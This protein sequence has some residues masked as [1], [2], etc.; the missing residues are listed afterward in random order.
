MVKSAFLILGIEST[1]CIVW[2]VYLGHSNL[3]CLGVVHSFV[4]SSYGLVARIF[5]VWVSK[6]QI[7]F[8]MAHAL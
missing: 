7:D 6:A 2:V 3:F 4:R 8:L 5:V 1:Y